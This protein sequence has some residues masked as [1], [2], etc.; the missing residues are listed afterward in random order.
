[1][2]VGFVA[3]AGENFCRPYGAEALCPFF[4]DDLRRGLLFVAATRPGKNAA[5]ERAG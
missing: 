1:M 3:M 4:S 2:S 5:R